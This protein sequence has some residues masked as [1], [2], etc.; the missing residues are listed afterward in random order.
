MEK[1]VS[2]YWFAILFI[3]AAAVVYMVSSFY[4][5]SYDVRELE[6]ELL[7]SHVADCLGSGGEMSS[8]VFLPDFEENFLS[9]C[10]LN[11]NSSGPWEEEQYLVLVDVFSYSNLN[12]PV[13]GFGKGN[14]NLETS[15]LEFAK[16]EKKFSKCVTR[17]VYYVYDGEQYLVEISGVVRKSEKNVDI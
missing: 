15:C 9:Y 11:F 5:N 12:D 13:L 2:V 14:L 4:G 3:V 6:S 1:L 7:V 17:R 16:E 8:L 10:N